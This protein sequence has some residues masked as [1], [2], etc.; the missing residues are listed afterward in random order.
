MLV[1]LIG[2]TLYHNVDIDIASFYKLDPEVLDN[3]GQ[4]LYGF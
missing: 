2:D 4:F 3:I 1:I